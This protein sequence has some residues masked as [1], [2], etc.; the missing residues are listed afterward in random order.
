MFEA[1]MPQAA[2]L[3]KVLEAVKDLVT[4]ANWDCSPAGIS[5]QAMDSSHVSLVSLLMRSDGFDS[6]RCDRPISLG[7]NI[8][9]MTKIMKCANN[10]DV[11]T[12]RAEDDGDT[13]V[14]TFESAD[15]EK[16]S[17]FEMKLMDIDSEHLGIPDQEHTATVKM[18]A[19]EFHGIC[20]DLSSIGETVQIS[21][22]KEGVQFTASGDTGKG[23]I[24]LRNNSSVDQEGQQVVI[25]MNEEVSL[26]FAL[27]YLNFFTKATALAD[28]VTLSM[29]AD[30]PLVV[31][32]RIEDMGY[33]RYYLAPKIDDEEDE[34]S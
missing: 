10:N 6:Y 14:F 23:T 18:P 27:R 19:G 28:S 5:L 21:V 13:V 3:K 4:D 22:T 33:I 7:I 20:R 32:Y 34:E 17:E 9:S 31:E 26:S 16:V 30:I 1:R 8:A 29:T 11:V 15:Q 24:T 2:L 12:L 25:T